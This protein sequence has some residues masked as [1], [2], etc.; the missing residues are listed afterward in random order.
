MG[1]AL[2]AREIQ[3]WT[4][5]TGVLT[6]DPRV[7]PNAQTVERLSYAEAAELAYFGARFSIQKRFNPQLGIV[8]QFASVT[9]AHRRKP[10]R[11]SVR[12]PIPPPAQ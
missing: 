1:A 8:F 11:L 10:E 7:V 6:A 2:N 4:D 3:I 9:R 12:K 5:V